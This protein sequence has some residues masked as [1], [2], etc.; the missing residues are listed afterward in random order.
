MLAYER[1]G[2]ICMKPPAA[3]QSIDRAINS[4]TAIV[5]VAMMVHVTTHALSRFLFEAPLPVTNELVEYV[6]MPIVALLGIPSA[7]LQREHIV[8]TLFTDLM[9]TANAVFFRALG[10]VIGVVVSAA[11]AFFGAKEA[12]FNMEIG[13]VAGISAV[14]I[15]PIYFIVPIIFT[16]LAALYV[17]NAVMVIRNKEAD[18]DLLLA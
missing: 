14:T 2:S 10:A 8:A 7:L 11:W 9:V 17:Y 18:P 6:Y 5:L 12:L 13:A 16:V 3:V 15:W 4:V 1:V